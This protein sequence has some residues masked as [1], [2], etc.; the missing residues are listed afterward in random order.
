MDWGL[1]VVSCYFGLFI[2]PAYELTRRSY[3][4][5]GS[6]AVEAPSCDVVIR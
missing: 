5:G 4:V 1:E 6:Y 2:T 3:A